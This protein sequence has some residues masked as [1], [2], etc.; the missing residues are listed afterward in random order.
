[1]AAALRP[2]TVVVVV[3]HPH[4]WNHHGPEGAPSLGCRGAQSGHHGGQRWAVV[5]VTVAKVA[6]GA[7]AVG[8][9]GGV[10]LGGALHRL[11][12]ATVPVVL[13]YTT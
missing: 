10:R 13:G 5:A 8:G 2:H 1:M 4:W 3:L 6:V 12:A 11:T 7:V 9:G